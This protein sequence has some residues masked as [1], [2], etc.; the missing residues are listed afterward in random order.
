MARKYVGSPIT[1]LNHHLD[2]LWLYEAYRRVRRDGAPGI[3]GQTV[4]D[5]GRDLDANL[6]DLWERVHSGRYRAPLVKR[7]HIPKN[8]TETRPIGIPTVENRVLERAVQMLLEPIYEVDFLDCSYGFRPGRSPHDA[9]AAV[10][11][12]VMRMDGGWVVDVDVKQ[13]FDTI[14]HQQLRDIVSRRIRDGVIERL[15]AKWLKAGVWEDGQVS[16]PEA[17]TPQGGVISPLLSNIYLHEVLDRWFMETIR[18]KL[19]G[20]AELIRFADDFIVICERQDEALALV[21]ELRT[22]F[23]AHG[24]TIHPEK[25]RVV[26]FRH[27]WKSGQVPQTFDFLGFTHYW[28]KTQRGGYAV[29]RQ[30][31]GK[32]LHAVLS[33][34]RAWCKAHRHDRLSD[35]H[36]ELSAQVR[37]HYQ[38]Y[39]IRG[40]YRML[41]RFRHEV[42]RGWAYWLMRRSRERRGPAAI[43]RLLQGHLALPSA[44]IVHGAT[45]EPGCLS[46]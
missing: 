8:E 9:L 1:T 27:P 37:G 45:L 2:Q 36:R 16:Y 6:K 41:Q 46:L 24:L 14:P 11:E 28:G 43:W 10:R 31:R 23:T 34:I 18:P 33:R 19:Q 5:Y 20:K 17:G 26:D 25:T 7:V 40:N 21:A 15:I 42:E 39:G 12:I 35:Q 38:Y 4:A 44:H 3:D 32:K 29:T 13:Y 30:T 22:R